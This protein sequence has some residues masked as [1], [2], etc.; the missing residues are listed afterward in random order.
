VLLHGVA[1]RAQGAQGGGQ[2]QRATAQFGCA[3]R[4]QLR[5][6]LAVRRVV[7]LREGTRHIERGL[8]RIVEGALHSQHFRIVQP[9][10][11]GEPAQRGLVAQRGRR[12]DPGTAAVFSHAPRIGGAL[13]GSPLAVGIE[14]V[15]FNVF[16]ARSKAILGVVVLR[17][18]IHD[19]QHPLAHR[20]GDVER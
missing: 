4:G 10:G 13:G 14:T 11:L 19:L 7:G 3:A 6:A 17:L 5:D 9:A 20:I 18:F 1:D 15:V 16:G 8:R 2:H 12:E